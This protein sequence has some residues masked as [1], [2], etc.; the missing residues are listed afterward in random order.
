MAP[1]TELTKLG[2]FAWTPQAQQAFEVIKEKMCNAPILVHKWA[3]ECDDSGI[4][5][6][7]VLL[8]EGKPFAYFGEKLGASKLNYSTYNKEFYAIVRAL[9]NLSHHLRLISTMSC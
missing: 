8:Q 4:G 6:G 1:I 9:D 2:E 7:V 5:I 3:K